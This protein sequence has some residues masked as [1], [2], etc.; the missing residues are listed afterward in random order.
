M[1]TKTRWLL[2]GLALVLT[3]ALMTASCG[4]TGSDPVLVNEAA[5]R[6]SNKGVALLEQFDYEGAA[7]AFRE[8]LELD[9]SHTPARINL[10][11]ALFLAQ[12]L[13]GADREA[14]IAAAELPAALEPPYVRGLVA[15]AQNRLEDALLEFSAV[16]EADPIDV[17]T[18]VNLGQIY[19]DSRDYPAAIERLRIAYEH[20]PF[21]V[22]AVYNLGL[23]LARSGE[24]AE[25]Q[26]LLEQAQALRSTGYAVTYNTGYLQQGRYAAAVASTGA[27]SALVDPAV[28]PASFTSVDV[29][30]WSPASTQMSPFGR[31]YTSDDLSED[32]IRRLVAGLGGGVTPIDFDLDGDLDLFTAMPDGQRLMRNDGPGNWTEVAGDAGLAGTPEDGVSVGAIVADF[33]NDE[34]PDLF[35]L[36]YGRSSLYRNDGSGVFADVTSAAGLSSLTDTFVPGAAAFADVDHDGDADLVVAGLVDVESSRASLEDGAEDA[37]LLF[38]DEFFAGAGAPAS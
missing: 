3:M 9:A 27:E 33:D 8:A 16:L 7:G 13:E 38:P 21:N 15:R 26:A 24:T 1:V 4:G 35:V 34:A 31:R 36:R 22:T 19:L 14:S 17:G 5:Y 2:T 37:S 28:P 11:V 20:E 32:G 23:A 12:D 6:A 25:G 10:A 29:A 30:S 18:N